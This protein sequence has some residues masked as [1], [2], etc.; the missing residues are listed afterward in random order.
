MDMFATRYAYKK[1][2]SPIKSPKSPKKKQNIPVVYA[3]EFADESPTE[4]AINKRLRKST[5]KRFHGKIIKG[6]KSRKKRTLL[7]KRRRLAVTKL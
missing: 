1:G 2:S 3:D 6:G 7:T 5:L 4:T